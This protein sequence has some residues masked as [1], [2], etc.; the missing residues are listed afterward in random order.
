MLILFNNSKGLLILASAIKSFGREGIS[1]SSGLNEFRLAESSESL[2]LA[3][4][5]ASLPPSS[6]ESNSFVLSL[7]LSKFALLPHGKLIMC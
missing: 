7:I 5:S 2:L 1:G 4:E 6:N 3:E